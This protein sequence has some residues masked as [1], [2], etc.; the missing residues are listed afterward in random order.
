MCQTDEEYVQR[1][2][3]GDAEAFRRL[4]QRHQKALRAYLV[5]RLGNRDLAEEAAQEAFVRAW[6]SLSK[7]RSARAFLPWLIGIASRAAKEQ[8]R[9]GQKV[10]A[11]GDLLDAPAPA[12]PQA[13]SGDESLTRAVA[14]L[15]EEY[16]EAVLLRYHAG[17]SCSEMS[18]HLGI[19]VGSVTKRLSRAYGLLREMLA[20]SQVVRKDDEVIS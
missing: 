16:R 14:R 9:P 2:L 8:A 4:V 1:S 11:A 19:P 17:M 5:G 3:G 10:R 18:E 12:E 15:P 20:G 7:L 13:G 6:F